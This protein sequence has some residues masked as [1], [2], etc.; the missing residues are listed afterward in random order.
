MFVQFPSLLDSQQ[1]QFEALGILPELVRGLETLGW[2]LPRPIQEETIPLILGGGDVLAV[3]SSSKTVS[4]Y[5][6]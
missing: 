6:Q 1:A 5:S 4:S 3:F 2:E